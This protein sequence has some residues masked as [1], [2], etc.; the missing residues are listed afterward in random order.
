MANRRDKLDVLLR[1]RN[2]DVQTPLAPFA[3]ERS[4]VL[5]ETSVGP[6]R[7]GDAED[8][9]VA[10]VPL[11]GF[12]VLDKERFGRVRF[13]EAFEVRFLYAFFRDQTVDELLLRVGKGDDAET[14]V[15]IVFDTFK[16]KFDDSLRLFAVRL[17]LAVEDAAVDVIKIDADTVGTAIDRRRRKR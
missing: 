13:K 14:A 10:L 8:D 2:R 12:E 16:D 3:V 5:N 11:D 6:F 15:G 4:E 7:V 17:G 9:R 1:A